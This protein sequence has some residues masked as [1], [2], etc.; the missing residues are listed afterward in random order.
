VANIRAYTAADGSISYKVQVRLKGYPP[1]FASF[2][3]KT[4]AKRWGV[5]TEAAIRQGRYFQTSESRKRTVGQLCD[6]YIGDVLPTKGKSMRRD[7]KVQ[8]TW[9]KSRIGCYTLADLSPAMIG[10]QRDYL[11]KNGSGHRAEYKRQKQ[12]SPATVVRY[13]AALSV[14]LSHAVKEWGWLDSNPVMKVKKPRE[15]RGRVRFLNGDERNRLLQ[16]CRDSDN[17]NLYPAVLLAIS[18]GARHGEIMA[19]KWENIDWERGR[20][21][22]LKTKNGDR[23][24]LYLSATVISELK[25]LQGSAS[26]Q[27]RLVFSS[28]RVSGKPIDLKK[29][30]LNALSVASIENFRFHD[31]R[32]TAASYLAM[33]GATLTEL[34]EILGHRTL[35]MVKRYAHLSE[36]HTQ[37]V[38]KRM[39]S[40]I[41]DSV[42]S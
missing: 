39:N 29:A 30:W 28:S 13:M 9:W 15:A 32:H 26:E 21:T 17:P 14:A 23:R 33:N 4:D 1:Q 22:L 18:T 3:R 35:S 2:E 41:L 27:E 36:S 11:S 8:L 7:Q 5:D 10:E 6:R 38:V 12:I 31:L 42:G 16:A 19:L 37:N 25:K 40:T 20:A 34:S 24:V